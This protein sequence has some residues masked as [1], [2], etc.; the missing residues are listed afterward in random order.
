[1]GRKEGTLR[2]PQGRHCTDFFQTVR[3]WSEPA[4]TTAV[5]TESITREKFPVNFTSET[6]SNR[7]HCIATRILKPLLQHPF[8][9][10]LFAWIMADSRASRPAIFSV[11]TGCDQPNYDSILKISSHAKKAEDKGLNFLYFSFLDKLRYP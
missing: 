6:E 9:N 11:A 5:I 4:P 8:D 2:F 3:N 10:K 1:M 7:Y